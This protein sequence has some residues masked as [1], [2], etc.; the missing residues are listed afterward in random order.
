MPI[1]TNNRLAKP[2]LIA[3]IPESNSPGSL[4]EQIQIFELQSRKSNN[5]EIRS[6]EK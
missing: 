2:T 6:I 4:L 1:L 5:I 3:G